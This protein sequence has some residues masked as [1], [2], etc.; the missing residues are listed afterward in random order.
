MSETAYRVGSLIGGRG[1]CVSGA[2]PEHAF[3]L[4]DGG[5]GCADLDRGHAHRLR[6]LEVDTEV[7]EE[8]A[9]T[10]LHADEFARDL[11]EARLGLATT[12][13]ARFDDMIEHHHH[14][15]DLHALLAAE[16]VV[17]Q[18]GGA[19]AGADHA[20]ERCHHLRADLARQQSEHDATGDAVSECLRLVGEQ[21]V[22]L[23]GRDVVALEECPRVRVGIRRVH[24]SNEVDRKTVRGLVAVERFEGTGQ[25]HAAEI[26]EYCSD[27]GRRAYDGAAAADVIDP[28]SSPD[29]LTVISPCVPFTTQEE[30][31]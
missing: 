8:H 30:N 11:V 1:G 21:C 17:R 2:R 26:P 3:Q 23:L 15:A 31:Q 5:F 24:P 7:V 16:D 14:V 10:R 29:G 12:D 20:V 4:G 13:L 19:I 22:E 6:R 28:G 27:H 9:F 25:D 18:T